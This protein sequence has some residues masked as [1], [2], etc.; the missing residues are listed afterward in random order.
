MSDSQAMIN[1]L[2]SFSPY[3]AFLRI[4][5]NNYLRYNVFGL[6]WS[7]TITLAVQIIVYFGIYYLTE[8]YLIHGVKIGMNGGNMK[9]PQ[10]EDTIEQDLSD[11]EPLIKVR[12][13]IK[14]YGT[15]KA[16]DDISLDIFTDRVTCILGHNGAGK[17]TLINCMCG[18][19]NPTQGNIYLQNQ[20]IFSSQKVLAGKIG[21]CT[22][23]DVL[24]E[25]MTVLEFLTFIA[26]LKGVT[27]Y[28]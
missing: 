22:S 26:L 23:R 13:V 6:D 10:L 25:D 21:Y 8:V 20:D 24:Y 28:E 17:T 4:N 18:L 7:Q 2:L 9:V 14:Q 27:E 5:Y 16:V 3:Q 11:K 15:F 12:N 1:M 19:S